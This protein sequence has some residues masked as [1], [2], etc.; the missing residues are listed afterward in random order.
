[1]I[2]PYYFTDRNLKVGF[3]INLGSHHINHANSK[4]TFIPNYLEFGIEVRYINK[5][6]K[7]LYVN[8]ARLLNRCKFKNQT[9]FSARFATQDEDNQVLDETEL[10][11]NLTINHNLTQTDIDKTDVRSPLEYPIQQQGKK[12]SGW[13][14]DKNNSLTVYFHKTVVLNGSKYDK[15]PLRSNAILNTE[16]NDKYCFIWSVLAYL[17]PCKNNH[18]KR[19]TN[20]KHFFN[21]LNIKGFDFTNG[22]ECSDVHKYNELNFLSINIL[23]LIFYHDQNNWKQK[24]IPGEVSKNNSHRV[25]DLAIYT[26]HY[27]LIK[28]V[29]VILGDRN[30]KFICRQ[31]LSSYTGENIIMKHKQKCGEDIKTTHRTSNESHLQWKKYFH[32][33]PLYFRI[34]ADIEV[35]NEIDNST[36]GN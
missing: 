14:F 28:E 12:D 3:K 1:M 17:L 19:V 26:N 15:F 32:K 36:I 22:F 23:E 34:N 35:D 10:F 33:N 16:I 24:L 4:L 31:C 25:I 13:R 11:I 8:Y 9:V 27:L 30:K 2:N 7:E 6:M 29:D 21:E 5:I 18:P 20:Y